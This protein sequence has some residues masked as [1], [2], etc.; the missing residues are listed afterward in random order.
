MTVENESLDSEPVLTSQLVF[1]RLSLPS[2]SPRSGIACSYFRRKQTFSMKRI[3]FEISI[4]SKRGSV[5]SITSKKD[6]TRRSTSSTNEHCVNCL[7]G[8]NTVRLS[9]PAHCSVISSY[10]LWNA[11]LKLR[12]KQVRSKCIVDPIYEDVNNTFERSLVF[13]HKVKCLILPCPHSFSFPADASDLAGL[14]S[15]PHGSMQNHAYTP[16]L[17]SGYP[18]FT[19]HSAQ[20]NLAVVHQICLQLSRDTRHSHA[21]VSTILESEQRK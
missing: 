11:Y 13:M 18:R 2:L 4:P 5:T 9:N 12:R 6:R 7:E 16:C 14:L 21:S 20:S 17:R 10:K 8:K 1:V 3:V 19:G 15:V